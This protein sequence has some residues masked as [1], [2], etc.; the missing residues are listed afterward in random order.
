MIRSRWKSSKINCKTH[1]GGECGSDHQLLV[2][3]FYLRLPEYTKGQ[4]QGE[5]HTEFIYLQKTKYIE[6]PGSGKVM[7]KFKKLHKRS[8]IKQQTIN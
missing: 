1:L 4:F 6:V 5:I 3:K 7:A 2:M 8:N